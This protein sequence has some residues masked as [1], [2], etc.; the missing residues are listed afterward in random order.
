MNSG[1]NFAEERNMIYSILKIDKC[2]SLTEIYL[3]K[4]ALMHQ[5]V[6]KYLSVYDLFKKEYDNTCLQYLH[7]TN[8]E[9][10]EK[11]TIAFIGAKNSNLA[12]IEKKASPEY[13]LYLKNL[14]KLTSFYSSALGLNPH[15]S[16]SVEPNYILGTYNY[17]NY[18]N[19]NDVNCS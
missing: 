18:V 7:V 17:K 6:D 2:N 3:P 1:H 4:V 5:F 10:L 16:D 12:D 8:C 9:K 19:I 14:P 15:P 11:I 13:M